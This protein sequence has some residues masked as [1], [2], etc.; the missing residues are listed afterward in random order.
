M[1]VL[2][3]PLE[4]RPGKKARSVE[5]STKVGDYVPKDEQAT[6]L[7]T[8]EALE[9]QILNNADK[10]N[11]DGFRYINIA[12]GSN[13]YLLAGTQDGNLGLAS[14]S[15]ND[16]S[17]WG[18]YQDFITTD[19][20]D[21]ILFYY[22]E[23]L[24]KT[25]VSRWRMAHHLRIPRTTDV[26]SLHQLQTSKASDGVWSAFTSDRK[27][28]YP[29]Y[30]QYNDGTPS[31]FFLVKDPLAGLATLQGAAVQNTITGGVVRSCDVF[32]LTTAGSRAPN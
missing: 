9:N 11:Q 4:I 28:L 23:E 19:N 17:L 1:C 6:L 22:P 5:D 24:Q 15:I 27:A 29:A 25:G 14:P 13:K 21:R 20:S 31:K 32:A 8:G 10:P 3:T 12:A 26:L 30:C 2:L 16:Q 18:L 7:N